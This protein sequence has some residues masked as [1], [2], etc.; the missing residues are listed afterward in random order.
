MGDSSTPW[1]GRAGLRWTWEREDEEGIQPARI[2]VVSEDER[3]L[4]ETNAAVFG[5]VSEKRSEGSEG[6]TEASSKGPGPIRP[7]YGFADLYGRLLRNLGN[8]GGYRESLEISSDFR[9]LFYSMF[10]DQIL[11]DGVRATYRPGRDDAVVLK[12]LIFNCYCSRL[13]GS[14]SESGFDLDLE[15]GPLL[16]SVSTLQLLQRLRSKRKRNI[17]R[18]A[19]PVLL[20]RAGLSTPDPKTGGSSPGPVKSDGFTIKFIR[21]FLAALSPAD[22]A[23]VRSVLDDEAALLQFVR[24]N[25]EK[26]FRN[27][28][29]KWV[30]A[31]WT[32]IQESP[33]R[34]W[35]VRFQARIALSPV[36]LRSIL[37]SLQGLVRNQASYN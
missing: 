37:P 18:S 16:D 34:T 30:D 11:F 31:A 6:A 33:F 28:F 4:V 10:I 35:R 22:F 19:F 13:S 9:R 29:D 25:F 14:S 2:P 21:S 1:L 5:S 20:R 27:N 15:L 24:I 23:R 26:N 12:A 32:A 17:F 3:R 7:F 8:S 36:D